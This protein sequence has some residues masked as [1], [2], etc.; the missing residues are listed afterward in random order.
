MGR[1][2]RLCAIQNKPLFDQ[3][4]VNPQV[5]YVVPFGDHSDENDKPI[6]YDA[7]YPNAEQLTRLSRGV[8]LTSISIK[9]WNEYRNISAIKLGFS[10]GTETPLF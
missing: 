8:K 6:V 9:R 5:S 4:C 1:N 7:V 2:F 10:D 3:L